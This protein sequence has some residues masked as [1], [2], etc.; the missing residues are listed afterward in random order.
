MNWT[1]VLE[2]LA[3]VCGGLFVGYSAGGT[4]TRVRMLSSRPPKASKREDE[5]II[6]HEGEID[7]DA[8]RLTLR[9]K[10]RV[11]S[12]LVPREI[13]YHM[14]DDL[15][16]SAAQLGRREQVQRGPES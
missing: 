13:V 6:V 2:L 5:T 11:A 7:G 15:L 10:S 16:R 12:F 1:I 3:L 14:S 4:M 9:T 8:L